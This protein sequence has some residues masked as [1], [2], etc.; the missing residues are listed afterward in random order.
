MTNAMAFPHPHLPASAHLVHYALPSAFA[1]GPYHHFFSHC[2][3]TFE[4]LPL[5]LYRRCLEETGEAE[6]ERQGQGEAWSFG[7][8]SQGDEEAGEALPTVIRYVVVNPDPA[9]CLRA[10]DQFFALRL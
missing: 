1:R 5:G 2:I 6:E 9:L 3:R 8:G 4:C 10:D 7:G